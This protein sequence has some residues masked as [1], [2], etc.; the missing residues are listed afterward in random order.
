MLR[1]LVRFAVAVFA[2]IG[3]A[4][5]VAGFV[6]LRGGIGARAEPGRIETAAARTLR[7]FAIPR[8]SRDLKNPVPATPEAFEEGLSHFADHCAI[9]HGN[10]GSGQTELGRGL[11]PKPPDMRQAATQNLRDGELC[12]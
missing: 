4:A 1:R 6:L 9:C 8:A 2:L 5:V 3:V 11:Y 7:S 10:D 12:S